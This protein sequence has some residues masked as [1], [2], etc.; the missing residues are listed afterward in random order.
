MT[1]V[2][3]LDIADDIRFR[4]GE[5][6]VTALTRRFGPEGRCLT[7]GE[8]FGVEPLS[9]RAYRDYAGI[10]TLVAYHAG[11]AA[12]VWVDVGLGALLC[13]ETW[14]AAVT[15]ISLPIAVQ[16]WLRRLR[17]PG[18]RDQ[19]MP[20]MLA[21]PSLEMT[22]VRQA[23]LGEAVNADMEAYGQL[24]F[25]DPSALARTYP[26]RAAGRA[27]VRETGGAVSLYVKVAD[28]AWSAPTSQ[29]VAV[30]AMARGGVLV[31]VTCDRDPGRLAADARYL[32]YTIGSGDVLLGWAPLPGGDDEHPHPARLC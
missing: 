16:R 5:P 15:S 20:I 6:T 31:G 7:C 23:G 21:R 2:L 26:L 17:G 3:V 9:V 18:T 30:L 13:Q 8:R 29:P 14:V 27:W 24:G 1:G 4:L 11:C 32:K 25:A 19:N 28:R 22:R 10:I 12:S